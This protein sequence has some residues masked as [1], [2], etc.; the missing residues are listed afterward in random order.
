M[1]IRSN[2]RV[3]RIYKQYFDMIKSGAKTVEIRVAYPSMKSI[4]VGTVIFFNDDPNCAR[5]VKRITIYKS[6]AE[7]MANEDPKTLNPYCTAH[8]Q[9]ADIRKIF[10]PDKEKIGVIAF[11]LEKA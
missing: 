11:E 2:T 4:T 5:R 3:M 8:Q 10:S 1:S 9:L 6:F 7:M